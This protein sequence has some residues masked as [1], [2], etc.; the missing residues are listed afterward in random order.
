MKSIL[1]KI[2]AFAFAVIFCLSLPSCKKGVFL[3][4]PPLTVSK[5]SDADEVDRLFEKKLTL[6]E[7]D[8]YVISYDHLS[9]FDE[10]DVLYYRSLID[11]VLGVKDKVVLSDEHTRNLRIVNAAKR[12]PYW[13]LVKSCSFVEG[14]KAVILE[15]FDYYLSSPSDVI[16][17]M[18]NE[19]LSIINSSV[20]EG[21]ND[22][23]KALALY[24]HIGERISY[25]FDWVDEYDE[26]RDAL[27][28]HGVSPYDALVR[29]MGVCHTYAQLLEFTLRQ[30]GVECVMPD[31]VSRYDEEE[32][33]S[34]LVV[35][36]DGK[37]YHIDPTWDSDQKSDLVGL[38]FFGMTDAERYETG[39]IT[40][41]E[42][43][44]EGYEYACTDTR[45]AGF[46]KAYKFERAG[47]HKWKIYTLENKTFIFNTK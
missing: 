38:R 13:S 28:F 34:W 27:L 33:H 20:F 32:N 41:K 46:R 37:Y 14:G 31:G 43:L 10:S 22:T 29:N 17:F 19:Y 45:F 1:K 42:S 2:T 30:V 16:E 23:D 25:D 18:E 21:M 40:Y 39:I 9:V 4:V 8:P 6:S 15:Y 3:S 44:C 5:L 36:L 35:K 12:S 47:L 7:I 26:K 24:L 11:A